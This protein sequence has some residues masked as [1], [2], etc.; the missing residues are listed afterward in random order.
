MSVL[1]PG[2]SSF[3]GLNLTVINI[4]SSHRTCSP[5]LTVWWAVPRGQ[6]WA[7]SGFPYTGPRYTVLAARASPAR[8]TG[9]LT[10]EC[11]AERKER[12]RGPPLAGPATT[13]AQGRARATH[14]RPAA[15]APLTRPRRPAQRRHTRVMPMPRPAPPST[16]GARRP[17]AKLQ[18][19]IIHWDCPERLK[20]RHGKAARPRRVRSEWWAVRLGQ[21][22]M[23]RG[24]MI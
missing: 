5:L 16:A 24:G 3:L 18:L 14:H 17:T 20:G 4:L 10:C 1:F 7:F 6:Y 19:Q 15:R 9:R 21:I 11:D 23:A 22:I 2:K 8:E 13:S 12:A